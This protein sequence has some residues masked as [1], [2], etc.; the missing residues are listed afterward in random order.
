MKKYKIPC[1]WEMY[2]VMEVEA[3][4]LDAA[5][6]TARLH[7]ELP[8]NAAYVDGSFEVDSEVVEDYNHED[9]FK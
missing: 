9:C 6:E 3:E 1:A 2:G 8:T 4:S 5:I 7:G